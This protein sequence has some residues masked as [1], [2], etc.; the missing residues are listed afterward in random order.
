MKLTD[1]KNINEDFSPEM[2]KRLGDAQF[3]M[4]YNAVS[5]E[6]LTREDIKELARQ[7][8]ES[9]VYGR[10]AGSAEFVLNRMHILV[11]GTAPIGE[12]E[13]RAE[14]MFNIPETMIKFA[15]RQGI[16]AFGN[17]ELAKID[18]AE[19]PK[20][21][22][23]DVATQMMADYY[24]MNKQFLPKNIS[25]FRTDIIRDIMTGTSP[26]VAFNKYTGK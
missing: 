9:E 10:T 20:K 24:R 22:K 12:T 15:E 18:L 2:R 14:T 7:F 26:E 23:Q 16:D 1:I 4:A 5:R 6:E 21:V 11:H 19:R 3:Q 13:S 17:I 8:E 25:Q